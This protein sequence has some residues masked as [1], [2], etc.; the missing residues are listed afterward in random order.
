MRLTN[1]SP[2][3]QSGQG[4]HWN[5][6]YRI[7]RQGWLRSP[8]PEFGAEVTLILMLSVCSREYSCEFLWRA[9]WDRRPYDPQRHSSATRVT[10]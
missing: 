1:V 6:P 2:F 8:M 3:L 9:W 5:V 10:T 4:V 7:E